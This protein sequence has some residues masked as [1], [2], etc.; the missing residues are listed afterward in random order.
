MYVAGRKCCLRAETTHPCASS[1]YCSRLYVAG[2]LKGDMPTGEAM[3]G[4]HG[5]RKVGQLS[6]LPCGRKGHTARKD[7]LKSPISSCASHSRYM[8][9]KEN[10]RRSLSVQK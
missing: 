10:A 2:A 7:L 4:Q 1:V 3:K 8:D 6:L 5:R 9:P